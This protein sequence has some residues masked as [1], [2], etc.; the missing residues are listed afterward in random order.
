MILDDIQRI[1]E[2][3][4]FSIGLPI[5]GFA[6]AMVIIKSGGRD[7]FTRVHEKMALAY[8]LALFLTLFCVLMFQDRTALYNLWSSSKAVYSLAYAGCV[9]LILVA[10]TSLI[11]Y[12]LRPSTWR[13]TDWSRPK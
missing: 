4:E 13:S 8:C 7:R 1:R 12:K 6:L 9:F 2:H 10:T 5:L 3:L 11:C